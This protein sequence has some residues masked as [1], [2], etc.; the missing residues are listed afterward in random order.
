MLL[1]STVQR[2]E[3]CMTFTLKNTK[4]LS[5]QDKAEIIKTAAQLIKNDIET[6]KQSN[7]VYPSNAEMA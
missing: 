7:D 4:I 5:R 1:H 2:P 6:I 3:F